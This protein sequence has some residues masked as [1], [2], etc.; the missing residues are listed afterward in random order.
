M[1][2]QSSNVV[3]IDRSLELTDKPKR[4]IL[5]VAEFEA[6]AGAYVPQSSLCFKRH[7]VV[8]FNNAVA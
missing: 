2:T 4:C 5:A 3:L 6:V 1:L 7:F 8:L